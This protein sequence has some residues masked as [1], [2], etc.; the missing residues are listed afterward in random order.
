V[1][2]G[3]A[4]PGIVDSE[5]QLSLLSQLLTVPQDAILFRWDRR[6]DRLSAARVINLQH[7][8]GVAQYSILTTPVI[9]RLKAHYLT[10]WSWRFGKTDTAAAKPICR[11]WFSTSTGSE[12]QDERLCAPVLSGLRIVVEQTLNAS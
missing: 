3:L 4:I 12:R 11:A 1:G 7:S 2:D 5:S 8:K 9:Q 10:R 6:P